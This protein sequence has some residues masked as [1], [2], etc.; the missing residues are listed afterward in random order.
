MLLAGCSHFMIDYFEVFSL[1]R[2]LNLDREVLE[3]RFHR[4]QDQHHP[5]R[6]VAEEETVRQESLDR[7][8]TINQAYRVL[9]DPISRYKHLLALYGYTVESSKQVPKSLLMTVMDAQ[10]K[11]AELEYA[12]DAA[13]KNKLREDLHQLST[14]LETEM[15]RLIGKLDQLATTWDNLLTHAR[16]IEDLTSDEKNILEQ[17]TLLLAERSYIDTLHTSI[18]NAAKGESAIIRH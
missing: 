9:R 17:L 2:Q 16:H 5:D 7:S 6:Y 11:I 12:K 13:T 1:S 18:D 4:L 8:S 15:Q 3:K 10:E 14:T